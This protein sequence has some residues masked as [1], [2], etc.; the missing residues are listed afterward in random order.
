MPS[1]SAP[2]REIRTLFESLVADGKERGLQLTAYHNGKM[3]I[4]VWAGTMSPAGEPV[5]G[6]TLFPLYSTGK[7]ITA[8]IIH[9]LA[10]RGKL[11]YDDPIARYWPAFAANGKAAITIRHALNHT[12]G[13]ANLPSNIDRRQIND[14]NAMCRWLEQAAPSTTPGTQVL[15]H[16]VTFGWILG[17]LAHR[18]DGRSFNQ[19]VDD[20]IR[21]PLH[22]DS[23]F[24]GIPDEVESLVAIAEEGPP[25]PPAKDPPPPPAMTNIPAS[26]IPLS[27]WMSQPDTRRACIPA[28]NGIMNTRALARHYAALLPG[29]IDGVELLT[30]ERIKLATEATALLPDS[31]L[32]PRPLGYSLGG[33]DPI[34]GPR[35]TAFGHHGFGGVTGFADPEAGFAYAFARNRFINGE[36]PPL[37]ANEV[38]RILGI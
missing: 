24:F 16:A 7:G 2:S 22:I 36:T 10:H 12:A 6:D 9:L 28:S 8:T 1:N 29:G 26:I 27:E 35:P 38:R 23:L 33:A 25:A 32:T 34:M 15:Y 17:E 19:I 21:T 18:A 30:P 11:D 3:V 13:L 20:E 31:T 37:V 14:W 5:T 4:D